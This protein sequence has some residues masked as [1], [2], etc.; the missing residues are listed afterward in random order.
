MTAAQVRAA[1]WSV[2]FVNGVPREFRG[3]SQNELPA[4][5]RCAFVDFVDSLHR[6][7]DI[8][9]RVANSVTL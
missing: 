9:D 3:K 7:G 8:T 2:H 5:L 1:F 4:D 6:S